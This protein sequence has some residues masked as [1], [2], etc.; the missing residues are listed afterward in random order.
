MPIFKKRSP[1]LIDLSALQKK[2]TLQRSQK[3]AKSH[4]KSPLNQDDVID[5]TMFNKSSQDSISM[6][7]LEPTGS[8]PSD[9]PFSSPSSPLGDFL[10]NLASVNAVSETSIPQ[11]SS[12]SSSQVQSKE[13]IHEVQA[14]KNKL[15]DIEFKLDTFITR[16]QK[17]EEKLGK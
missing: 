14:L 13:S 15:E 12:L 17:L 2:G 11:S 3:I 16:L 6:P 5:L 7:Q 9:S 4:S 1:E 10:S 8:S